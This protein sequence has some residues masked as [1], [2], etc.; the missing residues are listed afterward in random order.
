MT[1]STSIRVPR[2]FDAPPERVFDA[3][4]DPAVA[5]RWLFAS[6]TTEATQVEID[7]RVGGAWSVKHHRDR[8]DCS[9]RGEYVEIARPTRLVF[10][11]GRPQ[12]SPAFDLVTVELSRE[13]GGC[14]VTLTQDGVPSDASD[15]S[16]DGWLQMFDELSALLAATP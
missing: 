4:L 6:E 13:E 9:E 5:R 10:T 3:F 2:H 8:T 16:V 7:P 14:G 1:A 11:F 12:F 15:A